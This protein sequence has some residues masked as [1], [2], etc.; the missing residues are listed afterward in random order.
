MGHVGRQDVQCHDGRRTILGPCRA[1]LAYN[2]SLD[3]AATIPASSMVDLC[4]TDIL[5][6]VYRVREHQSAGVRSVPI[7]L[8]GHASGL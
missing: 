2:A 3:S 7:D 1:A 4:V 6:G 8:S 5:G